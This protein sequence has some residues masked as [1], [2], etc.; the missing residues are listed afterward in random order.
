M[1]HFLMTIAIIFLRG[2]FL[3]KIYI[4]FLFCFSLWFLNLV[5]IV[6][7]Q[8][9]KKIDDEKLFLFYKSTTLN[10]C[11]SSRALYFVINLF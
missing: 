6:V 8:K 9:K 11:T 1:F 4:F 7:L 10:L 3:F 2:Y 5:Q